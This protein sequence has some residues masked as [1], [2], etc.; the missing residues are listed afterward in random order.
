VIGL[1]VPAVHSC[2]DGSFPLFA[3]IAPALHG[4]F[5][6]LRALC[7]HHDG[8]RVT[9]SHV[10]QMRLNLRRARRKNLGRAAAARVSASATRRPGRFSPT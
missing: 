9:P 8:T 2:S 4:I 3:L 6:R 1:D 7:P 10:E 5:L